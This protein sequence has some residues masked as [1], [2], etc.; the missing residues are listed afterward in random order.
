MDTFDPSLPLFSIHIPKCAGT[1]FS[2][3]LKEWFGRGY[4]RHHYND[5]LNRPPPRHSLTRGIWT[6][7]PR[8]GLCIHGHFNN[9]RGIRLLDYYPEAR[10]LISIIRD[11]FHLHVSTYFY[12]KNQAQV[13]GRGA[14]R[15]GK[16]N[17]I[18]QNSSSLEEYLERY[19]RPYIRSLLPPKLT[20]DNFEDVLTND[21]IYIGLSENLQQSVNLLAK[22]LGFDTVEVPMKNAS[23]WSEEVPAGARERFEEENQLE[24]LISTTTSPPIGAMVLAIDPAVLRVFRYARA[25]HDKCSSGP[26]ARGQSR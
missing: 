24:T 21:F 22:V 1:S 9:D 6:K 19:T 7:R 12:L 3:V 5:K 10:Q 23:N 8:V 20:L 16:P 15:E 18:L 17:P 2:R 14:Y 4:L 11:P 13:G 26:P 25:M